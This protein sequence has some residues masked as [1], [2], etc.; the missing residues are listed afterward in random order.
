[1]AAIKTPPPP[2]KPTP[3]SQQKAAAAIAPATTKV[4]LESSIKKT[5]EDRKNVLVADLRK[6]SE[7]EV[8]REDEVRKGKERIET[9]TTEIAEIDAFLARS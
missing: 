3:V 7:L 9:L 2:S 5:V 4:P 6:E 8:Q 1:M